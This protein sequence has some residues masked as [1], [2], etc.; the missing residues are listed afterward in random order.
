[1]KEKQPIFAKTFN[2]MNEIQKNQVHTIDVEKL[3]TYLNAM[4]MANNLS[5]GEFQQFVEIAQGFGL[6]PF[7]REIYANKY[8]NQFSVIVGY[9][10]YIKRA[11]RTGKLSGW[12]VTTDGTVD[13][14]QPANST[15]RAQITIHRR[16][17]QHPFIHEVL[18]AEYFGT[19][20]D[21]QLNKFWREKPV[22]MIKKVA[23]AQ[24]FRLCFSD[25]LGGM[26]YTAEELNAMEQP[27]EAA[28]VVEQPEPKKRAAKPKAE[29]IIEV[30]PQPTTL[31]EEITN[32]VEAM[33]EVKA[34]QTIDEL[35]AVWTKFEYLHGNP[36]FKKLVNKRKAELSETPKPIV[37]TPENDPN[38]KM[39][40]E[41]IL[42]KIEACETAECVVELLANETRP[43][44]LD[45]GMNKCQAL[46][47]FDDVE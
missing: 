40:L 44:V 14:Q 10:T 43:E 1:L 42:A 13:K 22:T 7:K 37:L 9:E 27:A 41:E 5:N 30:K 2:V 12:H 46:G 25:E 47:K 18:F 6:N 29:T 38:Q 20:R 21:G 32:V 36:D 39:S 26:P 35:K 31:K 33:D 17:F 23:M 4:G 11:E 19:T 24:G 8:G 45:A 15:L 28:V 3:K 16:D 34:V